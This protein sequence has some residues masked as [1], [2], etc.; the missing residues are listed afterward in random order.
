MPSSLLIDKQGNVQQA[1]TGVFT[2]NVK[3]YETQL[4]ALLAI[5]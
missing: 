1:H 4:M 3:L 5:K 2:K